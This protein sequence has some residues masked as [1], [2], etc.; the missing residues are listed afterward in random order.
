MCD[1]DPVSEADIRAEIDHFALSRA[2]AINTYADMER[3]LALLFEVLLGVEIRRA[4]IVFAAIQTMRDRMSV[5]KKLLNLEHGNKYDIFFE[6]L[7][8]KIDGMIRDRNRVVHWILLVRRVGGKN[9]EADKDI[10]LAEHPNMF[11]EGRFMR[12]E[13]DGFQR[14]AEFY[15]LL[16]FQFSLY[17][18]YEDIIEGDPDKIP[19]RQVFQQPIIY[20]PE[21][22]HPLA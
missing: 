1:R 8:K 2:K 19:W 4:F 9:F 3:S 18:K 7:A 20:P 6:S 14:R 13:I 10:Y 16:L 12:H 21:P 5:I 15:R 17:I 22:N 11:S